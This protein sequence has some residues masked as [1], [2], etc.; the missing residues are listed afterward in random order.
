MTTVAKQVGTDATGPVASAVEFT[1]LVKDFGVNRVLDDVSVAFRSGSIHALLGANGSGKSTLIKILAGY[2]EPTAGALRVHG[3]DV[4]MPL[5]PHQLHAMGIR[6]VHQDLGLVDSMSVADNLALAAGFETRGP[7]IDWRAQHRAA[8]RDLAAVG[9]HD[10]DTTALI[11]DLG[12]VQRTLVAMARAL[13]GLD[14]DHGVLVLDEPTAR[15]PHAQ[16]EQLLERCRLL[17]DGGIALVYVSH[18]LDE[19]FAMADRLTVLRNGRVVFDD[20]VAATDPDR[21]ADLITGVTA[22]ASPAERR[23]M[24]ARTAGAG[25]VPRLSVSGLSGARTSGVSFDVAGGEILAVTG[26]IGS[27]RSELGRLIFGEQRAT[28]GQVRL[29][30]ELVERAT[31]AAG[32]ARG[33]GYVPQ[34]RAQGGVASMTLVENLT[35]PRLRSFLR[36]GAL[37]AALRRRAAQQ[38]IVTMDVQPPHP[39][40]L[41]RELSG[42]NQQKVILA[43]W[44][45]LPLRL[46]ILD[47]PTY[48]VDIGAR[49]RILDSVRERAHGSGLSVL[50]I[51]SDIDVVAEY[52]DRVLV[53]RSGAI[54]QEL[55]GDAITPDRIAAASYAID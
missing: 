12:P 1:G 24:A 23:S 14:P 15:L 44:L 50:L 13:R 43:K 11:R 21:L 27:G 20:A 25:E 5:T 51:D 26:L 39:T 9:L 42:G 19:V 22:H 45:D 4:A 33:I 18:R 32:V 37:S 16:V 35:Q 2:H 29:D 30:G 28:A 40:K 8:G 48:G 49:R 41:L 38:A 55:T 10:I 3:E 46:L 31:P 6:F 17:R 52:A 53:M 7:A 54:V 34:D 47:E 36:R